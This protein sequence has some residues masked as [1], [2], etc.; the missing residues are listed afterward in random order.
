MQVR[1][2]SI[3]GGGAKGIVPAIILDYIEKKLQE[4]AKNPKVRLSEFLDFVAGTAA[5]S[6]I[7]SLIITP[8]SNGKPAFSMKDII[9]IIFEFNEVLYQNKRKYWKKTDLQEKITGTHI[10]YFDHWK[11]KDLLLPIAITGYDILNET[12]IIFTNKDESKKYENLLV[13]DIVMGSCAHPVLMDPIDFRDGIGRHIIVNANVIA[14]NPSMIAYIEA[15]K[16][17]EII[18]KFKRITPDNT[19]LLSV[20]TGKTPRIEKF[21]GIEKLSKNKWFDLLIK[22]NIQSSTI[23]AEYESRCMYESYNM[24]DH[25]IRIEPEIILS[26]FD[27][28][29]SSEKNMLHLHQ[30][31]VNFV[32]GN[33][34]MLDDIALHLFNQDE[35]Y[36]TMLF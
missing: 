23:I 22:M 14:N 11:M 1:I 8:D 27:I 16:T 28:L 13:K 26:D 3:D 15:S 33:K 7:S 25:Y 18:D 6:I 17:P 2:L 5:G 4:L 21:P 12:P 20:G 36:S 31:A 29:N 34:G 35:R 19:F 9:P 32:N 30:D 24:K 10:K